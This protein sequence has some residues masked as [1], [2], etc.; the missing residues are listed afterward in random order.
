MKVQENLSYKEEPI[1]ILASDKN[2]LRN[3]DV[4]L[5]KLLWKN[6]SREEAMWEQEEDMGQ[7]YPYLF[8]LGMN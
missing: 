1:S 4:P 8:F 6:H 3:K 7:Q 5:V 2:V